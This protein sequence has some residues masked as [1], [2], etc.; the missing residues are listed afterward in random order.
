MGGTR[1][2]EFACGTGLVSRELA[3]FVAKI[4]G[5]DISQSMVD[6]YNKKAKEKGYDPEDVHA[7]CF[8]L[9]GEDESLGGVK[10]DLIICTA[11]FH[12]LSDPARI[13]K[14][15]SA[16]L[17]PKGSLFVSDIFKPSDDYDFVKNAEARKDLE[18]M[19]ESV[20][21]M[22]FAKTVSHRGGFAEADMKKF[23]E[24]DGGL[25]DFAFRL[26]GKMDFFAPPPKEGS[27]A[28]GSKH[29]TGGAGS[30]GHQTDAH[31]HSHGHGP[32]ELFIAKGTKPE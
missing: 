28:E 14:A 5:L 30:E 18:H 22:S 31:G 16:L 15:L 4:V 12:H 19:P 24:G 13:T 9:L 29:E 32:I 10:F 27:I 3:P 25:T 23:L 1:M 7:V 20:R 17:A 21:D 11:A 26:I 8:N 2:L 6:L